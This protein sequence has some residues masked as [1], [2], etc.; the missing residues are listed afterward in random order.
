MTADIAPLYLTAPAENA[1]VSTIATE[2]LTARGWSAVSAGRGARTVAHLIAHRQQPRAAHGK[3]VAAAYAAA[4]AAVS[5]DG[6]GDLGGSGSR[7]QLRRC[8][9]LG[10]LCATCRLECPCDTCSTE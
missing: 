9:A 3:G 5:C 4:Y 2:V 7:R 8:D 10:W 1:A 6:C